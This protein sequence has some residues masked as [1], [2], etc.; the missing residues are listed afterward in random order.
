MNQL[1]SE[2]I[3]S[4][5]LALIV[6]P[7]L[8]AN[9]GIIVASIIFVLWTISLITCLRLNIAQISVPLILLAMLWQTFLY[10]GLFITGH[11]A[12]HGIV[13]PQNPKLNHWI[14][15]IAVFMF[16]LFSYQ[17][18]FKKHH[19]HHRYPGTEQDPDYYDHADQNIL[20]WYWNF[21]KSYW[22]RQ[23]LIGFILIFNLLKYGFQ[24]P[25]LNLTLFWAI[26]P[27]LSSFQLFYFG[28]FLPHRKLE[29]DYT[30][31][32]NARTTDF[33]LFWSFLSCY[34]FG[35][36]HEHHEFPNVPWWQLPIIY[37]NN[38]NLS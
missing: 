25:T 29:E 16:G 28:T 9:K 20:I 21:M 22:T 4:E 34:H 19:L 24:I 38:Q 12:M 2:P 36:H 30:N 37:Q 23:Q 6:N 31:R 17:T 27:L 11:D 33:P 18:L 13:C 3:Q 10:T 35:Y 8:I 14:G 1:Y 7:H 15:T 26:P 5:K 32:H